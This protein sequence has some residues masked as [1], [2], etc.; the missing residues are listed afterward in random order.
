MATFLTI[1]HFIWL[2]TAIA[3]GFLIARKH[4]AKTNKFVG[5]GCLWS[6]LIYLGGFIGLIVLGL[7][8]CKMDFK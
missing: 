5:L 2:P 7:A 6:F 3:L 8:T 4:R 1:L